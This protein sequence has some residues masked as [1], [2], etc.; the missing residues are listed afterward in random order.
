M[1]IKM[2]IDLEKI[3][4]YGPYKLF[5]QFFKFGLVGLCNTAISLAIYYIF[6]FIDKELYIAGNIVGF[7][8]STLN[9]YFWNN[10]YVFR[11]KGNKKKINSKR[12]VIKTYI[13]YAITLLLGTALLSIQIETLH[14]NEKLAPLINLIITVP[15]NFLMNKFWV[16]RDKTRNE[17]K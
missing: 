17:E 10:K 15:I 14:I 11:E 4:S 12:K 1:G 6:V 9:A 13:S 7:L 8:V 5:V 16:Y 2:S 3:K